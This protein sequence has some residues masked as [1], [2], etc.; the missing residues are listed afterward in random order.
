MNRVCQGSED[1]GQFYNYL[2]SDFAIFTKDYWRLRFRNRGF[3]EVSIRKVQFRIF[4]DDGEGLRV[5]ELP[6]KAQGVQCEDSEWRI[7]SEGFGP[8]DF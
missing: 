4:S 1:T 7:K 6:I 5:R 3:S 8:L 2:P